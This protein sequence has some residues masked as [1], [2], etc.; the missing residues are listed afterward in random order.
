[1]HSEPDRQAD[2]MAFLGTTR[3]F[4]TIR[5]E[6]REAWA[7]IWKGRIRLL[8]ADDHWQGTADGPDGGAA[9]RRS[10]N[11]GGADLRPICYDGASTGK[12]APP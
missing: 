1:M 7:D 10:S 5:N 6:N 12:A 2:R 4:D 9:W 3:G 11:G 8:G